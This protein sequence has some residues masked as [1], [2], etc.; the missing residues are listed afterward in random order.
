MSYEKI[1]GATVRS[2][3]PHL[4]TLFSRLGGIIPERLYE[5]VGVAASPG[6][7]NLPTK[8]AR[9]RS[10]ALASRVRSQ[11]LHEQAFGVDEGSL[12]AF[13]STYVDVD[14]ERFTAHMSGT[15]GAI[16]ASP[17]YGPFLGGALLFA[18][19]A[20]TVRPANVFYDAP[21]DVPGNLR[22]DTLFERFPDRLRVLHNRPP[23]LIRAAKS[24]RRGECVS[25]MFDVVQDPSDCVYVPFFG[26]LY[27]AMPGSAVLSVLTGASIV[28][29]YTVPTRDRR[30]RIDFGSEIRPDSFL[31]G[32]REQRVFNM[33]RALFADME[34]QL[35]REPW[36][37]IYWQ[38]V[39]YASEF[40]EG[41]SSEADDYRAAVHVR[42]A[43][44]PQLLE[45]MPELSG[46]SHSAPSAI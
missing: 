5:K 42:L 29:V 14:I 6:I 16:F 38:N 46:L 24:L 33:T 41:S 13:V 2:L 31:D 27:P 35:A 40:R 22:F 34:R 25:I 26:R 39:A 3:F 18:S 21:A 11:W 9:Y 12:E 1:R 4:P 44:A 10:Q 7:E 37:W 8:D 28:P 45:L 19:V 23:D 43:S 30:I 17:H 36:H 32:C 20:S 15:R